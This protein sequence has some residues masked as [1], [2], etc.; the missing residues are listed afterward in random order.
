MTP[1]QASGVCDQPRLRDAFAAAEQR[2]EIATRK[3]PHIYSH[4]ELRRLLDPAMV[5]SSRRGAVQFDTATF[6]TLLLP[7]YG[8]GL[9]FSEAIRL[10]M[11]DVDLS[12]AVL[13]I[14]G[15]KFY[16]SRLVPIGPHLANV[17][18][19]Y[20]LRRRGG[21]AQGKASFL[22]ANRDGTGSPA[23]PFSL[24]SMHYGV[25]PESIAQQAADRSLACTTS[26]IASRS[27][28]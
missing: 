9:R 18:A 5:A 11:A 7:L 1:W 6:R 25:S 3:P 23:A 16:K 13:T 14:R 21:L 24:R 10:T 19:N 17:L 27:T 15:T 28:A 8:A 2:T 12:E 26:G 20:T 22:L 4:D